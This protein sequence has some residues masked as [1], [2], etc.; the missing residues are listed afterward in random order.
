MADILGEDVVQT[1]SS[2]P[3][4]ATIG[5]PRRS[6]DLVI[7]NPPYTSPVAG[8]N[9]R[10][11][12]DVAGISEH[13]RQRA[14]DR[15]SAQRRAV[16][17]AGIDVSHGRAGLG[18]DFSALADIKLKGDGVFATVLPLTAAHSSSWSNF[19]SHITQNY[20]NIVAIAYTSDFRSMMPAD[21]HLNEMLL[22]ATKRARPA[23]EAQHTNQTDNDSE[24]TCVNLNRS[25]QS[26]NDAHE[27]ARAI[28]GFTDSSSVDSTIRIADEKVGD[29]YRLPRLGS[30]FPWFL[31]GM[32]NRYVCRTLCGLIEGHFLHEPSGVG[33]E[34]PLPITRMDS[35]VDI[36][37]T[38]TQIGHVRGGNGRG[39]FVFD[40]VT[41][42]DQPQ[43]PSI[44]TA[45]GD[46]HTTIQLAPTHEGTKIPNREREWQ[47]AMKS[48]SNTFI[49]EDLRFT[50]QAVGAG[51][52][53]RN[54]LGSST[55][56]ALISEDQSTLDALLIWLNS[57]F[58]MLVRSGYATT[59]QPGRARLAIAATA[60]FPVPDFAQQSDAG[61]RARAVAR[62]HVERLS[63]LK[64]EPTSYAWRD[65]GRHEIDEVVLE[66]LDLRSD[67]TRMALNQI[68]EL[69]CREPSVHGGNKS[70]TTALGIR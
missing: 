37:P 67:A 16:K 22:V 10:R 55:W 66:M 8:T 62:E 50:S 49:S 63:K 47:D 20:R 58:G 14:L 54:C 42:G 38:H 30:G 52:T 41:L 68:R 36:G 60:A 70:I 2:T 33:V 32:R 12:F 11:M 1:A 5:A 26:V 6:Y 69:W 61:R 13:D 53:E 9:A 35:V 17:R 27:L 44:W 4:G 40:T 59:T 18:A 39:A 7:Q 15:L 64:L 28:S 65:P 23:P 57:T 21:T 25:A 31:L 48:A 3:I 19:R 43:Y 56:V 51:R 24:I 34:L 45:S 46:V 29:C